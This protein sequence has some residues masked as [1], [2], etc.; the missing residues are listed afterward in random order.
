MSSC[1]HHGGQRR[2]GDRR[3]EEAVLGEGG[4]FGGGHQGLDNRQSSVSGTAHDC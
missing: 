3:V 1:G 2:E 4:P